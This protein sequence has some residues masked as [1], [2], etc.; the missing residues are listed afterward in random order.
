MPSVATLT[1]SDLEFGKQ[2]TEQLKAASFPV[3]GTF[4][5]YDE[6]ADDWSLMIATELVDKVGRKE[7]YLQLGDTIRSVRQVAAFQSL[8]ISV[9]SPNDPL[10]KA[11]RSVFGTTLSVE[12]VRLGHTVVNGVLVPDAYLY[13]IR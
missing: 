8:R 1:S 2:V 4:W 3:R 9:I 10:Y 7:T 5:L 13:E 12:G 6:A 11:L